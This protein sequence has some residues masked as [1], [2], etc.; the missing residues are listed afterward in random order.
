M[1]VNELIKRMLLLR[2]NE[3]STIDFATQI[4][5]NEIIIELACIENNIR[6]CSNKR[7][8]CHP[9]TNLNKLLQDDKIHKFLSEQKLWEDIYKIANKEYEPLTVFDV[10]LIC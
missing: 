4:I 1:V 6:W 2:G 3:T 7:C 9:E 5:F 10:G 8:N